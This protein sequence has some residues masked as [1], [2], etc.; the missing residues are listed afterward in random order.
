M[1]CER[2]GETLPVFL[3]QFLFGKV[4][5][6]RIGNTFQSVCSVIFV[7]VTV[8][9]VLWFNVFFFF[10]FFRLLF[11]RCV[12]LCEDVLSPVW[13][14]RDTVVLVSLSASIELRDCLE[15]FVWMLMRL[16]LPDE[17]EA[18]WFSFV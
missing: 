13:V 7:V 18:V 15:I 10:F 14:L 8:T 16:H 3:L 1:I 6:H 12:A 11:V 17:R 4:F 2:P 9:S 5:V